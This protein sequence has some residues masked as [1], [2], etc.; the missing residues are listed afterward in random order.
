MEQVGGLPPRAR[1]FR[2]ATAVRSAGLLLFLAGA[3]DALDL[4]R[5]A[6]GFLRDLAVLLHDEAARGLVLLQPAENFR[7]HAPVGALAAVLID[8]VEEGEF[9][10]GIGTGLLRHAGLLIF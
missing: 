6:A 1:L 8:D 4:H 9:A 5:R 7:R 10:L 2:P 3:P